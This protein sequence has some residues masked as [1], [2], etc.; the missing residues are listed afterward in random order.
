[1]GASRQ[2]DRA[3]PPDYQ[4]IRDSE[5][6]RRTADRTLGKLKMGRQSAAGRAIDAFIKELESK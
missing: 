6:L 2:C 4:A 3:A 1:M 5:A